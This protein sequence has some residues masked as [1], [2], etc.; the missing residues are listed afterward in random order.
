[1]S[2]RQRIV[3]SA[4]PRRS[5]TWVD[6]LLSA[7]RAIGAQDITSLMSTMDPDERRGATVTRVIGCL[8]FS[9]DDRVEFEGGIVV[10][11]GIGVAS[12]EAFSSGAISDPTD[13]A[14]QPL[15]GWLYRCRQYISTGTQA[16]VPDPRVSWNFDVKSQRKLDTGELFMIWEPQLSHGVGSTTRIT[17]SVRSLLR[18]A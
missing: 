6:T 18:L 3:R 1:M 13:P 16:T 12:Q 7:T 2:T 17:G 4:G 9:A 15:R 10:D 14:A 11:V 8:I 5:M